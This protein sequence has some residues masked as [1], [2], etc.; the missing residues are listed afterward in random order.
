MRGR[1]DV[2]GSRPEGM[3]SEGVLGGKKWMK[4]NEMMG[5]WYRSVVIRTAGRIDGRIRFA[6]CLNCLDVHTVRSTAELDRSSTVE[7]IQ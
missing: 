3:A 5:L 6:G 7:A 4:S 2:A 1:G